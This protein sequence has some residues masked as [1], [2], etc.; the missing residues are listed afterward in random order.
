MP[1]ANLLI[2]LRSPLR[3]ETGRLRRYARARFW[4]SA[5]KF[6]LAHTD[7][8]PPRG[9]HEHPAPVADELRRRPVHRRAALCS[10]SWSSHAAALRTSRRGSQH[11][12]VLIRRYRAETTPT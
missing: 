12:G 5:K 4:V 8:T 10:F 3:L 2:M 9:Q 11:S 7:A 6:S 1:Y